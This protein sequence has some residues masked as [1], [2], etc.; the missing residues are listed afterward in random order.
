MLVPAAGN[1]TLDSASAATLILGQDNTVRGL[2][3]GNS[4]GAG[5][6]GVAVGT[7]TLDTVDV[8]TTGGPALHFDGLT[9]DATF[10]S[11]AST[12]SASYGLLLDTVGGTLTVTGTTT[13][14][15]P[16]IAGVLI[17][18]GT[19]TLTL[20]GLEV[21]TTAAD[22]LVTTA[23]TTLTI[24]GTGSFVATTTG[25]PLGIQN[26]IGAAG[27]TFEQIS[28]DGALNGIFLSD[29]G[30]L[31][32]LTVTGD[33]SGA[34]NGSGG[35]LLNCTGSAVRLTNTQDVSLTQLDID[36]SGEH[37]IFAEGVTG[38]LYEDASVTAAGDSDDEYGIWLRNVYGSVLIEDV[39]FDDINEDAIQLESGL[40]DDASVDTFTLR[41]LSFLDHTAA[42]FGE[43]GVD[44]QAAA[45]ANMDVLV[46]DCSFDLNAEALVGVLGSS[47]GTSALVLTVQDS[48]FN[49]GSA[50][51]SGCIQLHAAGSSTATFNV[52]TNDLNLSDL[53]SILVNNDDEATSFVTIRDNDID[54]NAATNNGY[55]ISL[56]QDENGTCTA[57]LEDNTV[58]GH[59]FD[60]IRVLA[61][62][63]TDGTGTMNVT[64]SGNTIGTAVPLRC[65]DRPALRRTPTPSAPTSLATPPSG[66]NLLPGSDDDILVS[67]GGDRRRSG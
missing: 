28:C 29:T 42:G 58:D 18:A 59:G 53:T 40:S 63:T 1:P 3:V 16:A 41:R 15:G 38:L 27:I 61:R 26:T 45:T 8:A 23:G 43:H 65:R 62:D 64:V 47:T 52:L 54:A 21:T 36:T 33:G 12:T 17:D 9:V 35:T 5:I 10:G 46:D 56:R 44:V 37:G 60:G 24:A 19:A 49:A 11:L 32:G 25:R 30:T 57:L 7:L 51:G 34:A 2:D 55:G 13:V 31:G 66:S 22:G 67:A 4:A 20:G 14:A 48:T 6:R 39:A 50:F